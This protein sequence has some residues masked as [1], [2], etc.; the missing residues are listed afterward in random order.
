MHLEFIEVCNYLIHRIPLL[1]KITASILKKRQENRLISQYSRANSKILSRK[2]IK[3]N[4][5]EY[6]ESPYIGL[7]VERN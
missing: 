1:T 6:K 7:Q 3:Q 2:S 5:E 4:D